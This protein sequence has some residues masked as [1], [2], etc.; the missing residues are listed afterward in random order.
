MPNKDQIYNNFDYNLRIKND[1]FK[2]TENVC[3]YFKSRVIIM[4]SGMQYSNQI[5]I[6][7][8]SVM[9]LSNL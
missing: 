7:N 5:Y 4:T 2:Y 9:K 8:I 1:L 3:K 6:R